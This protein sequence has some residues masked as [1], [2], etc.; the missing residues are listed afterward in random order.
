MSA[1]WWLHHSSS[2]IQQLDI[3]PGT[4]ALLAVWSR[5]NRVD[6]YGLESGAPSLNGEAAT[7]ART[8][9]V[10]LDVN[11]NARLWQ[12]FL[13]TLHAPNGAVLPYLEAPQISIYTTRD[14]KT[15]LYRE[16]N[17]AVYRM[18]DGRESKLDLPLD[19]QA[20]VMAH[21]TGRVAAL[22]SAGML[23]LDSSTP[24]Q[25]AL[26]PSLSGAL[27]L[28]I[29]HAGE[30]VFASDGRRLIALDGQGRVLSTAEL[31]YL[32]GMMACA[33]D[34]RSVVAS[35]VD[36]GVLRAFDGR[37]LKQ[38]HQRWAIDLIASAQQLQLIADFPP[39]TA[40]L[41]ALTVGEA[42]TIA[43]AMSGVVC[44]THTE[45]MARIPAPPTA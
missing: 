4:P 36:T 31:P 12:A 39:L 29:A 21:E 14:R 8:V 30:M 22:D 16:P 25:L 6:Y 7:Y 33:P 24:T 20:L 42:N 44:V 32:I 18:Q 38:T 2:M 34:G 15:R 28:A 23:Y 43:F 10:P 26:Q 19:V 5:P 3:L 45:S 41:S 1:T 17:G 9:N 11:R 40:S 35:D 27:L 37:T 13:E